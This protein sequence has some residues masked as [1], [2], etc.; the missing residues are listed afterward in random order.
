MTDLVPTTCM[1]C[2]VGCGHVQQVPDR[3]YG[4]ESVRGDPG[5]P[6]NQGLACQRGISETATPDGEWLTRP[7]VR[8]DGGLV[9]TTWDT[10]LQHAA[11]G[12]GTA[13][14]DGGDSVAVLG[15]GQQTNEAAYAL[16]KLARGGFGTR[17][18]DANTTLCMASAVTAYYD[19]FGSDAP[20]PTY[21]DIPEAQ[22]H[23][24]W[25]A[26]PAAAH[27]VM[28][29]WIRQSAQRDDSELI[30]V[31]PVHSETAAAADHHV[32]LEPGGDL[33]LA[34]AVLARV[35]ETDGVA[36]DFV[37]EATVGFD[38]LRT[39]FLDA[40]VAAEMAGVSM[41]DVDRLAAALEVPTLLYWGMGINQSVNGT[42]AAGAL[43]DLCLATGNLRPGSG[44]FSLTGQANSMGT[45]V[46]S[47]KGTWPGHRPFTEADH[48]RE[49]AEA[50]DVPVSRL[51]DEP[52]PGPVG[53]VDAIGDDVEAVYAVATNPV[54]GMPDAAHV[55]ANLDD[56]F[57]V[58]Q[59]AFH[60]E[61]VDYADVVL[62]AATWGESEGTTI[63][64]ERTVSR[65]RAATETPSGVRSDLTLIG[66]LADRLAPELFDGRPDPET[67]FD[68]FTALT[69]GTPAD[70]SGISYDRLEAETAV[71]WPAP[72]ADA[73]GGYRYYGADGNAPDDVPPESVDATWSFDT[74]SGRARFSTG[75]ARPLPEPTDETYPFT[76]TTARR[77]DA[78]NTGVRTREDGPPTARI[79]PATAA[80][81]AA[82]LEARTDRET[83]DT[84]RYAR[85]VSRRASVTARLEADEAIPDGVVWLPIHHPEVN[86]LTL[87]DV[88]PRS[89]EPNFKQCAV[90]LEPPRERDVKAVTEA[91][92]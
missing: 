5:H 3:G 85:I 88:D 91:S 13:L 8:E 79:S 48:R 87:P 35:I 30:V 33:A 74:Q 63:N 27:P 89:N 25:G 36:E 42:A 41:D 21:D 52:G 38:D 81:F 47:S 64:M 84:E 26:N 55:R 2:A 50:W 58:V 11:D 28:F 80:A 37:A 51:P 73:S 6:V 65:V 70:C 17:Y 16:G 53:I 77:P 54:A 15:S 71:R 45:R 22:R 92:A 66:Q 78:Y 90:R 39:D 61:T 34:R 18:Y 32:P 60:S 4:L 44:P 86:D 29:R 68:E 67:V 76:L 31:D 24:V 7:L 72:D 14:A 62:P 19:A 57:L 23:V 20:P 10:A 1:R 46:C 40:A 49:V 83:G 75:E 43:I 59:D 69:A 82:E 56:A 9:P 12:L